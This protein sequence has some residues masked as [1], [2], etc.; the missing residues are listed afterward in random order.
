MSAHIVTAQSFDKLGLKDLALWTLDQARQVDDQNPTVNRHMALLFEERG[1]FT[2][3]IALWRL[4]AKALP[5]DQEAGKKAMH[6]A[7]SETIAKGKYDQAV[8]GDCADADR[9]GPANQRRG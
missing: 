2:Q 6:L 4:V 1:Q 3:A 8:T 9:A 7:A 5:K